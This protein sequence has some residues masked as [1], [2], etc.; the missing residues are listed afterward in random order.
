MAIKPTV[1]PTEEQDDI[2]ATTIA[3]SNSMMISAY[4]GC[5]KTTTLQLL[6]RK[7][8]VPAVALAFNKSIATELKE[9]FSDNF[10][11]STMN[12]YGYGALMRG[13]P[14][15]G[16]WS[17]DTKKVGKLVS[18]VAKAW[19]LELG[20]DDWDAART[21]VVEA[22]A[23]GVI[24]K[25]QG[26][27][28]LPDTDEV[29]L[30]LA[31]AKMIPRETAE[32][33]LELCR[34]VLAQNNHL[35][36]RGIISF[37]DQIYYPTVFGLKFPQYPV[38]LVDEAQDLSSLQHR[39]VERSLRPDGRLFVCGDPK[40]AI[41]GFRGAHSESMAEMLLLR[42]AWDSK[43]LTLTFRCPK[44]IVARQQHHAPGFRAWHTNAEGSASR[45]EWEE[46]AVGP[47]GWDKGTLLGLKPASNA[48]L[49]VLCRNNGPLLS[50]A[51]KLI[52]SGVGVIML[53]RDIGKGLIALVKKI[54]PGDLVPVDV[55]CAKLRDWEER[56]TSLALANGH[57]GKV[58]GIVDRAECL[59]AVASADGINDVG[60]MKLAIDRLFD[61]ASGQV[62]LGSI[63]KSKGLEWDVV[64]HLDPW[65]VPSKF[66]RQAAKRGD[67]SQL[68]QE[69]NLKYVC[70]TRTKNVL[71]EANL[72][73]FNG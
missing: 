48:S 25:S 33:I 14:G 36:E 45:W 57:D 16:R 20:S 68:R 44:V 60:G 67:E 11:V 56:E 34:E 38:M 24:P 58:A 21:L 4:A 62:I 1:T 22:Q 23:A 52:R 17:I 2:V 49:A 47:V 27:G 7:I 26:V 61:S 9:R 35:T 29:W 3:S 37:D 63:H 66:A 73:D 50:L 18:E 28:L 10:S 72:E 59:R 19:K 15:V 64:V 51:F 71:V 13:M 30:D 5:A 55:F 31:D 12:G 54:E 39:M 70:E 69:W 42:K 40:Q 46:D 43:P 6:G 53:G 8:K 41:Y 65:R 32:F